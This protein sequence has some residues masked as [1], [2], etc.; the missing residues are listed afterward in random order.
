[1]LEKELYKETFSKLKA[2]EDTLSDVIKIL[3]YK[4]RNLTKIFLVAAIITILSAVMF[5]TAYAVNLFGLRDMLLPDDIPPIMLLVDNEGKEIIN[6]GL[7]WEEFVETNP[8]AVEME[9]HLDSVVLQGFPGSPEY[10]AAQMWWR[11]HQTPFE[12]V[13]LSPKEIAEVHGLIY[14]SQ[15]DLTNYYEIDRNDFEPF[16]ARIAYEP[17]IKEDESLL[18]FPGSVYDL[19][20]FNFG[21][22][23]GN[24]EFSMRST[25]KGTFDT[26]FWQVTD[27]NTFEWSYNNING[28]ELLLMQSKNY[29]VIIADTEAAFIVITINGGMEPFYNEWCVKEF[30]DGTENPSV[31]TVLIQITQ[32]DLEEFADM[33][34][35]TKLK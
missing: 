14:Q 12:G 21:G 7:P 32:A 20:T 3:S 2:S 34:D 29:S 18:V 28:S 13:R 8:D 26:A 30:Q 35:F 19:G 5:I 33:I 1:M 24:S 6:P 10:E 15:D 17:F 22:W 25:R 4:K 31:Q 9:Y 16:L 23:Y 27:I 11:M